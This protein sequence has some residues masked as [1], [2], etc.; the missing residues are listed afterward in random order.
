VAVPF[1]AS[2]GDDTDLNWAVCQ[3]LSKKI[4]WFPVSTARV[5]MGLHTADSMQE[6]LDNLG[7]EAVGGWWCSRHSRHT[8]GSSATRCDLAGVTCFLR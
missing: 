6:M 2:P 8:P 3:A 1:D 5:L 7:E 4:G